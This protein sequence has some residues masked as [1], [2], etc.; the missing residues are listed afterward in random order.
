VL[1]RSLVDS[2]RASR[3][4]DFDNTT[5]L[6]RPSHPTTSSNRRLIRATWFAGQ[7]LWRRPRAIEGLNSLAMNAVIFLK[8]TASF[9]RTLSLKTYSRRVNHNTDEPPSKKQRVEEPLPV[10]PPPPQ[11]KNPNGG[12]IQSYFKT[13]QPSASPAPSRTPH[14]SSDSYEHTS[15]TTTRPSQLSSDPLEPTSTPPS[16]PPPRS[17]PTIGYPRKSQKRPKRRLTTRPVL[18]PIINMSSQDASD[19]GK[20]GGIESSALSH[21]GPSSTIGPADSTNSEGQDQN[22]SNNPSL[23]SSHSSVASLAT[24]RFY[25]TQLDVGIPAMRTCKDC[26]MQYN[27]TLEE[28]RQSHED[29]HDGILETKQPSGVPS[30]VNLM[31]K[32]VGDARHLIRV[33]D[34]RASASLKEHAIK[35]LLFSWNDL[36]GVLPTSDDL[37]SLTANPQNKDHPNKVPRYKLYTYLVNLH[38]VGVLLVER[39][40]KGGI[41]YKGPFIYT[42][43]GKV[44]DEF[45][46]HYAPDEDQ[47]FVYADNPYP[48]YMSID[49]IW[50][51]NDMRKRGIAS[52]LVDHAR[53]SFIPGLTIS[54]KE[55]SFSGVTDMGRKFAGGY[56]EGV[57]DEG[58]FLTD[59][60]QPFRW[61][62]EGIFHCF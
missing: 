52:Q 42:E 3:S 1:A 9:H 15:T 38:V 20:D 12:T 17:E 36:G 24:K 53:Q 10:T 59:L 2:L 28:D 22:E 40:A 46:G 43:H 34:H 11:V 57:F 32:Y 21:L 33:M 39:I 48:C 35:A 29:Y 60:R 61:V 7:P 41:Y 62:K 30:G 27:T 18:A 6:P 13:L 54:K 55:I 16:S 14:L 26:G 23:P 31:D 8:L 25:Q 44:D 47:E 49:R 56:C 50:V 51:R 37:W 19:Y 4:R 58:P 5:L 45:V